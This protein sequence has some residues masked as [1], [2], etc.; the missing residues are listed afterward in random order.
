MWIISRC[1]IQA[2]FAE[3]IAELRK[4]AE[5]YKRTGLMP[6]L[7]AEAT[8]LKSDTAVSP[9]LKQLLIEHVKPLEDVPEKF[10]DWF[11]ELSLPIQV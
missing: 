1:V 5:F 10:K 6:V 3:C 7:D 4:K 9:E 8:V 11:V 2:D